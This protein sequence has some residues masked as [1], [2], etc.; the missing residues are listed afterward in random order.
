MVAIGSPKELE[1]SSSGYNFTVYKGDEN[2]TVESVTQI[3]KRA[4]PEIDL[5]DSK[6]TP[7]TRNRVCFRVELDGL[8]GDTLERLDLLKSGKMIRD[9]KVTS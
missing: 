8:L 5:R 9:Y 7:E 4:I 3:V 6:V 1:S 2:E